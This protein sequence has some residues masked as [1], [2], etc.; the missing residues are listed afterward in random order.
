[1]SAHFTGKDVP[2]YSEEKMCCCLT[3]QKLSY[4]DATFSYM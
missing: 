1:M 4:S 3:I 2:Y